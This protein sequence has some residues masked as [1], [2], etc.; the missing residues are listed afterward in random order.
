MAVTQTADGEGPH[1]SATGLGGLS[2]DKKL[3]LKNVQIQQDPWGLHGIRSLRLQSENPSLSTYSLQ[4]YLFNQSTNI[5][6]RRLGT[7]HCPRLYGGSCG[8]SFAVSF[9]ISSFSVSH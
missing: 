6:R 9:I 1:T 4:A 3:I 8:C 7:H 5:Y 2:D